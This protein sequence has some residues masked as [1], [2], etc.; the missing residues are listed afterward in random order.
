MNDRR[1][2]AAVASFPPH[3]RNVRHARRITRT[4]LAAWGATELVDS[5]EMVVS[6]LVTN[7]MRYGSGPVDLTLALSETGLRVS[8]TDEGTTL[9]TAR[10]AGADALGGRGLQIVR[11]LAESWDVVV[12]L[13]G[14]T[15]TCVLALDPKRADDAAPG[16][17]ADLTGLTAVTLSGEAGA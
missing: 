13:T 9:P 15:V 10:E 2:W 7:A 5:A 8:V 6:E 1:A 14:K 4:A 11:L 16:T 3:P 12:R 17:A